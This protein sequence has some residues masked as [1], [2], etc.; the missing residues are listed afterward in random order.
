M[1]TLIFGL[2]YTALSR[3]FHPHAELILVM[4]KRP[5]G[6]LST[7]HKETVNDEITPT[8]TQEPTINTFYHMTS[9]LLSGP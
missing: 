8:L 1:E 6:Y 9:L 2:Y 5:E 4:W 3:I 7:F